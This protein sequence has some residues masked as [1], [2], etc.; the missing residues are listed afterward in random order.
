MK[1][2]PDD[3]ILETMLAGGVAL[4]DVSHLLPVGSKR[5]SLRN[6][7]GI[8]RAYFHH[9]GA[10]GRAGYEG[11]YLSTKYVVENRDF[12]GAAYHFWLPYEE[13]TDEDDNYVVFRLNKDETRCYH[14]GRKAN[15]HGLGVCF[16]GNLS[17][18]SFSPYQEELAEALVPWLQE[19]YSLDEGTPLSYH[20]EAGKFG[21][22]PKSACP[23]PYVT[24]WVKDYRDDM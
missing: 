22:K 17:R 16:Q 2:I 19:N 5:Y 8:V 24:R 18:K 3:A 1:M 7:D 11:P 6:P 15:D 23:G 20:A 12:R 10:D 21:G 9:S 13:F 4:Y 14:T